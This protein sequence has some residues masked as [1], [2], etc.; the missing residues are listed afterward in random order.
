[1][2]ANIQQW[3]ED[4][5]RRKW[6]VSID[7][8]FGY[9]IDF[10]VIAFM[11]YEILRYLINHKEGTSEQFTQ[12]LRTTFSTSTRKLVRE[13]ID[14]MCD[15]GLIRGPKA[16]L[17]QDFMPR[18]DLGKPM[19]D[20]PGVLAGWRITGDGERQYFDDE[21]RNQMK[22]VND[23]AI[24]ASN[25]SIETNAS[26]KTLN[27]VIIP[28]INKFQTTATVVTLVIAFLSFIAIALSAYIAKSGV[29]SAD[30]QA[31]RRQMATNT[32][33]LDSFKKYEQEIDSSLRKMANDT[34]RRKPG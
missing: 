8:K 15:D 7:C 26:I 24:K 13:T 5:A 31:L 21:F 9:R 30:V 10:A 14:D 34:S 18:E 1:L 6:P 32:A 33:I 4:G 29:S 17:V 27:E 3:S 25:S 19:A 12:F 28:R 16:L 23:A 2:G 20:F 22:Q 11:K